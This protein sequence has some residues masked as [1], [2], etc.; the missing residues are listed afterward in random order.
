MMATTVLTNSRKGSIASITYKRKIRLLLWGGA[1]S[2]GD[3]SAFEFAKGNVARDY[4]T[5]DRGNFVVMEKRIRVAKDIVSA[6]NA[7]E[8][9]SIR[10]LD[11]WTHGGP[12]ALYLTTAEPP[13]PRDSSWATQTLYQTRRLM[14]H[15]S[16][17]YRSSDRLIFQGAGWVEGS[18]LV[19]D[20]NFSRFAVNAKLELHGCRTADASGQDNIAADLSSRLHK[21][22]KKFAVVI[23]H[24]DKA[25][26]NIKGGGESLVE[27]DYRHGQRVVFSNG[28]P[29]KA[30]TQKGLIPE[31]KAEP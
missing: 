9:G 2:P 1:A 15:N 19:D 30:S 25:N 8:D 24:A 31:P 23:G 13:P 17:L 21:A 5:I 11:V 12:Q 7:Q 22:G 4:K 6:V 3:N 27:H 14:L 26:P 20:I 18:A 29:V 10:S 16:S 28:I